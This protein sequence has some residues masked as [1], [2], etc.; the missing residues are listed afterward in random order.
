MEK[1]KFAPHIYAQMEQ[2]QIDL[3]D[4]MIK[5]S[6]EV[7]TVDCSKICSVT[8]E[9]DLPGHDCFVEQFEVAPRMNNF[10]GYA[11]FFYWA[12]PGAYI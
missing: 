1:P 5:P 11:F 6:A 7:T 12:T 4:L 9:F 10:T 3:G 2:S 8:K